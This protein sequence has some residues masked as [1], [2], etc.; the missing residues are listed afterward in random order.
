M[1]AERGK[2]YKKSG[3]G[4]KGPQLKGRTEGDRGRRKRGQDPKRKAI[5]YGKKERL[6]KSLPIIK[7]Q[8]KRDRRRGKNKET[9]KT[10]PIKKHRARAGFHSD[11]LKKRG[12]H[13]EEEGTFLGL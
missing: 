5:I 12:A 7:L 3:R 1:G 8:D 6:Q 9:E 2:Y 13:L 11:V 10:N 4:T